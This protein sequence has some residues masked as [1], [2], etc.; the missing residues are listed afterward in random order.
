MKN[1]TS[2]AEIENDLKKLSLEKK[3]AEEELKIVK[4][5]FEDCLKPVNWMKT[6]FTAISKYGILLMVKRIFK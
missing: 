1:Y 6:V 5:N 2:F 4:Y 3:I